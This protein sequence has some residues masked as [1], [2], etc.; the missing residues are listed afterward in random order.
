[1]NKFAKPVLMIAGACVIVSCTVGEDKCG[2]GFVEKMGACAKASASGGRTSVAPTD[3]NLDAVGD[4]DK[5][6]SVSGLYDSCEI[7]PDCAGKDANYCAMDPTNGIGFCT[8][9]DCTVSPDNCPKEYKCCQLPKAI[10]YPN[11]CLSLKMYNDVKTNLGF[12]TE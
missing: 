3:A 2:K 10:N 11:L 4:G 1:M 6:Q 7:Q 5:T 12:C 9:K 8:I